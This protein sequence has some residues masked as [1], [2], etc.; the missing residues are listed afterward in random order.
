[1][2][3]NKR[4]KI[5]TFEDY[6]M[7]TFDRS[8]ISMK[9]IRYTTTENFTCKIIDEDMSKMKSLLGTRLYELALDGGKTI[10]IYQDEVFAIE[11]K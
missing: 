4:S 3:K 10:E 1:M 5:K 7:I 6:S 9:G 8:D 2:S 11:E